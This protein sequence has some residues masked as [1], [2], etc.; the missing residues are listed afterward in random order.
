MVN[1]P[2]QQ[3]L[4]LW[5]QYLL[6]LVSTCSDKDRGLRTKYRRQLQAISDL[7]HGV[8]LN[9]DL[10]EELTCLYNGGKKNDSSPKQIPPTSRHYFLPYFQ[11][12]NSGRIAVDLALNHDNLFLIQG[13]PGTGKTACI[14]EIALQTLFKAHKAR[15]MICSPTHTAVDNALEMIL[16]YLDQPSFQDTM[17]LRYPQSKHAS[18]QQKE[19]DFASYLK[20]Y[21]HYLEQ[22]AP[23]LAPEILNEFKDIFESEKRGSV[24]LDFDKRRSHKL[25][26]EKASILGIT[27]NHVGRFDL[28]IS[29]IPWD[30]VILDEVFQATFPEILIPILNAEK[31]IMVGDPKQLPPVFCRE[32]LEVLEQ[33]DFELEQRLLQQSIIDTIFEKASSYY[34]TFL[35]TQYR[36]TVEIGDLVSKH[37]YGCHLKNGRQVSIPDSIQWIGYETRQRFPSRPSQQGGKLEN[38]IEVDLIFHKLKS[39]EPQLALDTKIA[40]IT[41]YKAQKRLLRARLKGVLFHNLEIDTIDAFQ[42]RQAKIVFFSVTRNCGSSRF[43]SDTRR[44]NV[45]ISRAQDYLYFVGCPSYLRKIPIF[46][47]VLC[48]FD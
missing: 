48:R 16:P 2:F 42:G 7:L 22:I 27:C 5:E 25:L 21:Q 14:A 6:R 12:Q 23:E 46:R 11:Q 13:P 43:Y 36:M 19:I 45:A 28:E 30:L 33:L 8:I 34:K 31:V 37:F 41:P 38:P 17:V 24:S 3:H 26:T 32:E 20:R 4:L 18:L 35:D 47:E 10:V 40:I 9:I 15:I 39:L 29:D 1:N 44:L